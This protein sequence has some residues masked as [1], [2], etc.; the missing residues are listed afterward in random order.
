MTLAQPFG[1]LCEGL[2][3]AFYPEVSYVIQKDKICFLS[4]KQ[5][6]TESE[7][8]SDY[9]LVESVDDLELEDVLVEGERKKLVKDGQWF[10]EGPFQRS[11][12]RNANGR[13]YPRK[14]WEKLIANSKSKPMKDMVEGG[15]I[16]HLE[17]PSDGRTD[18]KEG[19]IVT[20]SLSLRDDGVVW[21]K[22]EV[23]DTPNGRILQEYMRKKVRWGVSSRGNG[24]VQDDGTVNEDDY[25]LETW[26][27]VMRPSTPGAYP[28][29]T[30]APVESEDEKV[31]SVSKNE[32]VELDATTLNMVPKEEQIEEAESLISEVKYLSRAVLDD[33]D[34]DERETLR[35][36]VLEN[37]VRIKQLKGADA[38]TEMQ[39]DELRGDLLKLLPE[40]LDSTLPDDVIVLD[41]AQDTDEQIFE[42]DGETSDVDGDPFDRAFEAAQ[43]ERN[44]T[45]NQ[46]EAQLRTVVSSLQ[47]RVE[48]A[49]EAAEAIRAQKEAVEKELEDLK[50]ENLNLQLQLDDLQEDMEGELTALQV[51]LD[52]ERKAAQNK[53]DLA[54]SL[55]QELKETKVADEIR[56]AVEAAI[57]DLPALKPFEEA[58]ETAESVEEVKAMANK[59]LP[60]AMT[61]QREAR[62]EESRKA[63]PAPIS[64]RQRSALP[65]GS[66][67]SEAELDP[68]PKQIPNPSEGARLAASAL[69]RHQK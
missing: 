36:A 65:K 39:A 51:Q 15:M 13:V 60:E 8:T 3:G 6:L 69:N 45:E 18:G 40:T 43:D 21:G 4:G 34:E 20:R 67:I 1:L 62:L 11:D 42:G 59:L 10:V 22:A 46:V 50:V 31:D 49:V 63:Q 32:S 19:A 61:K 12:V 17:H 25:S 16:G 52:E 68:D 2:K 56:E 26:D 35:N 30:E 57:S 44:G 24:S 48:E 58:L 38:L 29:A 53:L 5:E 66:V 9:T 54:H 28:K 47:N 37:L 55:I 33:A 23:L 14:I 64:I 7:D 27:A 41:E